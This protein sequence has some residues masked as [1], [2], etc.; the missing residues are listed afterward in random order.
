MKI[1]THF[2]GDYFSTLKPSGKTSYQTN[3]K[4]TINFSDK[5]AEKFKESGASFPYSS[6]A[7][8][9]MIVYNGVVMV[10]DSKTNSINIGDMSNK[11]KIFRV[12]LSGGGMLNVN[13][14][15]LDDIDK[16]IGMF[17]KKD[18]ALILQ[19]LSEYRYEQSFVKKAED[20]ME[21]TIEEISTQNIDSVEDQEEV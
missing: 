6:K 1:N 16:I 18:Q 10:G 17:S 8:G 13:V 21:E 19:A 9:N 11:N 3:E 20:D 12:Q 4:T 5:I 2:A 7:N 14:D 15:N